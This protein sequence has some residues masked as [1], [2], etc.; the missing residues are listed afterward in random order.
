MD[1]IEEQRKTDIEDTKSAR[2]LASFRASIDRMQ[3]R[4][5]E[6][7]ADNRANKKRTIIFSIFAI[8]KIGEISRNEVSFI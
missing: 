2:L 7:A 1:D 3:V 6:K 5:L 8:T 4:E